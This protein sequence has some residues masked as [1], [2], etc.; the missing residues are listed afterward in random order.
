MT[1][2]HENALH[3]KW[4]Y[5]MKGSTIYIMKL[6]KGSISCKGS[7]LRKALHNKKSLHHVKALNQEWPYIMRSVL[8]KSLKKKI[9]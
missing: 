8:K 1:L 6:M 7:T 2:H 4:L 3:N 5:I 9:F